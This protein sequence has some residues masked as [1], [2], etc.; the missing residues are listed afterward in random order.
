MPTELQILL[1]YTLFIC[2]I[3][4]KF[5]I[6]KFNHSHIFFTSDYVFNATVQT[7]ISAVI[8]FLFYNPWVV[9]ALIVLNYY[10]LCQRIAGFSRAT[11]DISGLVDL[12]KSVALRNF[13]HRL[14]PHH[15]ICKRTRD[16]KVVLDV[17]AKFYSPELFQ[18]LVTD[19][20]RDYQKL[21]YQLAQEDK[22]K[23][24][25]VVEE[26]IELIKSYIKYE[27]PEVAHLAQFLE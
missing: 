19:R 18:T 7:S 9:C 6:L 13:L 24:L 26:E 4:T 2:R 12:R 27:S 20:L 22:G 10:L 3:A 25:A 16:L 1:V 11:V 17:E 5:A 14:L 15:P 21:R 23:F 8:G